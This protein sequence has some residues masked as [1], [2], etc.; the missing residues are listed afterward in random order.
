MR[1]TPGRIAG[2]LV[3]TALVLAACGE[4]DEPTPSGNQGESADPTATPS[5]TPTAAAPEAACGLALTY[6]LPSTFDPDACWFV[7]TGTDPVFV[8]DTVFALAEDTSNTTTEETLPTL[9]AFDL[10]SGALIWDSGPLPGPVSDIAAAEVDGEPGVA[11]VVTENDEG[12]AVTE[13]S[14]A[15]GYLAWPG[16]VEEDTATEA[17]VHITAQISETADTA[18]R[19][20]DQGVLAGDQL[21]RPGASEFETVNVDPEAAAVDGHDLDEAFVGVSGDQLLSYT[22]GVAYRSEGPDEGETFFGWVAR[23][24]DGSQTWDAIGSRPNE[25]DTIFGEG[26]SRLPLVIGD[27]ALTIIPTDDTYAAFELEWLDVATGELATPTP[28]DLAGTE[29]VGG[30]AAVMTSDVAALLT[31]SAD[32]LFVT[33]STLALVIDIEAGT[34]QSAS[35]DFEITGTAIDDTTAYGRTENGAVSI[36]LAAA[37]ATAETTAEGEPASAV[38]AVED[39]FGAFLMTNVESG[40]D[41]LVVARQ[42][43]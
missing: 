15:W 12:D 26:P 28:A 33:W 4:S 20:T 43:G 10:E 31:P 32:R 16:D 24:A 42:S 21:L 27:Y 9:R 41:N 39:G 40:L 18:V 38:V 23:G 1:Y 2:L 8:D 35:A 14:Q 17:A 34:V 29:P 3:A 36:D 30:S 7:A 19:W 11:L 5:D 6:Q 13:G 22:S 25:E 37:T